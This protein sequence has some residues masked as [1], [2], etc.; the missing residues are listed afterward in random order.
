MRVYPFYIQTRMLHECLQPG[1]REQP[2]AY[3]VVYYFW[4]VNPEIT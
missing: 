2:G 4:F 1:D 3:M